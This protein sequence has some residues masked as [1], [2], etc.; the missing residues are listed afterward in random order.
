MQDRPAAGGRPAPAA[1]AMAAAAPVPAAPPA[2]EPAAGPE[3]KTMI[4]A[5][6]RTVLMDRPVGLLKILSGKDAGRTFP[7]KPGETT[8]G[9]STAAQIVLPDES[10]FV[11][12]LHCALRATPDRV[13]VA[14]LS[15]T[16]GLLVNGKKV[17]EAV[18]QHLDTFQIGAFVLQFLSA[19]QAPELQ[20]A[21]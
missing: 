15:S 13:Q 19:S 16:N 20:P 21:R 5:D 12:R 11:S 1:P 7:L 8:L 6:R 17:K 14:D 18:L 4:L 10:F 3:R 9:R 2:A